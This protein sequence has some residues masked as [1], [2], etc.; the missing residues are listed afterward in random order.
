MSPDN[1]TPAAPASSEPPLP[2]EGAVDVQIADGIATVRFGHP[3]SNSLPGSLLRAL[4]ARIREVGQDPATRVIVLRSAGQGPFCAGAS[5]DELVAIDG[6]ERGREFFS[7]F[8]G[9]ILAMI[10]A[11][12]FVVTRVH[13][14][15]TGGGVGLVAASDYAL[16][17]AGAACKLSE[18]AVGI[19]PFV[20][21]PV[22]EKRIGNAAFGAMSVDADWRDAAWAER[23][24]LYARVVEDVPALDAAV[25]A[26]ARR[27][28][29]FNPEAMAEIK[30]VVWAGTEHWDELLAERAQ[31]SGRLVLS[32]FTRA[33]IAKFKA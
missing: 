3:K 8:A 4:A 31:I 13:G 14:K 1:R 26:A 24:G 20:V 12:Q 17:T 18:L 27:L 5:F 19:G 29:S 15:T 2:P 23:H 9:V 22:I 11:P 10:R 30:R 25:D 16:A 21:G 33:A 32:D 6:P 7:G 28:A